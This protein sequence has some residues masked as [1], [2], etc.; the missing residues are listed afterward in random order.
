[1][2]KRKKT[3][4]RLEGNSCSQTYFTLI[5]LLVVIAI[6]AILASMLLPALGKARETARRSCCINNLKQLGLT[7]QNYVGENDG[8][9]PCYYPDYPP[10]TS[11]SWI[12][13]FVKQ[14]Y[15]NNGEWLICPSRT[16]INDTITG[17]IRKIIDL[18]DHAYLSYIHYGYNWV[19]LGTHYGDGGSFDG[20]YKVSMIA[21]PSETILAGESKMNDGGTRDLGGSAALSSYTTSSQLCPTHN[22]LRSVNICW[23][24][25]HV[26]AQDVLNPANPYM[27]SPFRYGAKNK[28]KDP[29]NYWDRY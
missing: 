18:S 5:E 10:D 14:D 23:A 6:I 29:R 28:N 11:N 21:K 7:F 15:I 3:I 12:K 16:S 4:G 2:K 13:E 9:L 24:D 26:T 22:G 8:Y 19:F 27:G 1:M 17:D 25:G 20:S